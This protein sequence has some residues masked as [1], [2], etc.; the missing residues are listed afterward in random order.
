[1]KKRPGLPTPY[2]GLAWRVHGNRRPPVSLFWTKPIIYVNKLGYVIQTRQ[3]EVSWT[4]ML[5]PSPYE[6]SECIFW[7]KEQQFLPLNIYNIFTILFKN[8]RGKMPNDLMYGQCDQIG[9]N[10]MT[11]AKFY[12]TLS[13][14]KGRLCIW[15]CW[16]YLLFQLLYDIGQILIVAKCQIL[17]TWYCRLATLCMEGRLRRNGDPTGDTKFI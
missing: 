11:L 12:K 17:N 1:M 15:Q 3:Q 10:F 6:V 2:V 4:V 13:R 7:S 5:L 16:T 8:R 14:F 9:Q